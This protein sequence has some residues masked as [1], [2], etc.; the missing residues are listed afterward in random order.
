[1]AFCLPQFAAN[2]FLE[3][4]RSGEIDPEKL[5]EMTSDERRSAFADIVGEENAKRVNALFESKLLLKNQQAGFVTWAQSL[6]GLKPAAARDLLSRVQNMSEVLT[7][8]NEDAFYKDLAEQKLGVGVSSE[9]AGN[10]AD[11]AQKATD[12]KDAIDRTSPDGSDSRIKYGAEKV[13]FDRYVED[14]KNP[15]N[16][17]SFT[18]TVESTTRDFSDELNKHPVTAVEDFAKEI[19]NFSKALKA[20]GD[21]AAIFRQGMNVL[22]TNPKI[23]AKNTL[24]TFKDVSAQMKLSG[25]DDSVSDA[26]KAE[27]YSRENA[28]NGN[29]KRMGID[30]GNE[31]EFIPGSLPQKIPLF[32][33]VFKAT[34]VGF[35]GFLYRARA[36]LTDR[37]IDIAKKSGIDIENKEQ[38][39]SIGKMVNAL[40]GRG[41]LG[42]L[43]D[44]GGTNAV[45]F[46]PKFYKSQFDFLT[47]H[48]F[49]KDVTPF[50][51]KQAAMNLL[52]SVSATAG[53][54]AAANFVAPGSVNFDPRS[55]NFGKITIDGISFDVTGGAGSMITLAARLLSNS[56]MTS[57]GKVEPLNTG[58]FGA[59]T[60]GDVIEN[61]AQNKLSPAASV[62]YDLISRSTFNGDKPTVASEGMQ[63]AAP[64]PVENIAEMAPQ[65]GAADAVLAE[66]ADAL[67]LYETIPELPKKAKK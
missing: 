38:A 67:G 1:M 12:A 8:E 46:S 39:A 4:L 50:V 41:Y 40:T 65:K 21:L 62:A 49:Q 11:L 63:L 27:I 10:I 17:M 7:P 56:T 60:T 24:K 47:A 26:L 2:A 44:K 28:L 9:E 34:Q 48:Q 59:Q 61:F 33:R 6:S 57:K 25:T 23:W 42:K 37:Y 43:A 3:K 35:D 16:K 53:I 22:K 20:T 52:K 30:I 31:E 5:S 13:A 64:F 29:Y 45:F 58:A 55:S 66:I 18:Q 51:R 36:D 54:L 15:K 32:G 14:L 19:G